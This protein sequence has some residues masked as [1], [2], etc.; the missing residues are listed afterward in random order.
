[1][2]HAQQSGEA[3]NFRHHIE[4]ALRDGSSLR[5]IAALA[6]GGVARINNKGRLCWA[7]HFSNP[8]RSS[9]LRS[10]DILGLQT[11]GAALN[12]ELHLRTF[13]QRPIA[14]HLNR[15][16]VYK[17]VIAVSALDKPV[18]LCGVKPFHDTFFSHY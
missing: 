4:I 5:D 17:H 3:G 2:L 9:E 16:K 15:R 8:P 7:A 11:L 6:A 18:A 12:L 14:I 13:F 10:I 1:M